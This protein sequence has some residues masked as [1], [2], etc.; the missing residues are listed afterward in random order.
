MEQ[1]TGQI[2]CS[3]KRNVLRFDRKE[4]RDGFS[5]RG[6]VPSFHVEGV[7]TEKVQEPSSGK[8]GM[9]NLEGESI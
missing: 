2:C 3:G 6:R 5:W 7:K 8:S 9:R 1:K 4:S